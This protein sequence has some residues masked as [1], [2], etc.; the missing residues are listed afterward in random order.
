MNY[1]KLGFKATS[2]EVD[3]KYAISIYKYSM[4]ISA[5]Y[6]QPKYLE[7]N[8]ISINS[9]LITCNLDISVLNKVKQYL[10]RFRLLVTK[11]LG[12]V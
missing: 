2:I 10:S 9:G 12:L 11:V 6:S 1:L 4:L 7:N 5:S 8:R 3:S